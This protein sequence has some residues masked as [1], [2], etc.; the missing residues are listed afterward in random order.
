[1]N[2]ICRLSWVFIIMLVAPLLTHAGTLSCGGNI[3]SPGVTEQ[4]LLE[5]CGDPISRNGQEW[6]YE[7]PGSIPMRVTIGN[8]VVLFIQEV[9]EA[10]ASTEQPLGDRP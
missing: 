2:S 3:I 9:D 7:T 4:E 6:T 10:E 1:M 5:A 8:G